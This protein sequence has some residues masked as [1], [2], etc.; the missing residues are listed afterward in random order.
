MNFVL[1]KT[2]RVMRMWAGKIEENSCVTSN[3]QEASVRQELLLL[4]LLS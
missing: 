4:R 2:M 1:H 3:K